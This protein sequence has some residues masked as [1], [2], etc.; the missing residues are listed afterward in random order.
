MNAAKDVNLNPVYGGNVLIVLNFMEM[1]VI[2][3][4]VIV[5]E[6]IVITIYRYYLVHNGGT[7]DS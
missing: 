6:W 2:A 7:Y 3:A 5:V 4:V 1:E